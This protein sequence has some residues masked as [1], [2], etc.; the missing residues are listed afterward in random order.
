MATRSGTKKSDT[1]GPDDATKAS[2]PARSRP[3]ANRADSD[4]G[5]DGAFDATDD[6]LGAVPELLRKVLGMGLSGLFLTEA[7]IRR[8]VGDTIP[9]DWVDFALDQSDRARAEFLERVSLEVGRSI[10]N[11]DYAS[12][13]ERLLEG[14]TLEINA[15]IRLGSRRDGTGATKFSVTLE[16]DEEFE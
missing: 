7:T 5:A 6:S 3:K 11:I 12:V 8:A 2:E 9:K 15:R 16:E 14:R 4:R 13:L 10:E 1:A